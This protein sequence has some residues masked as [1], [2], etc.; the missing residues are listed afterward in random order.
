MSSAKKLRQLVK[1]LLE[2]ITR[3]GW[4]IN[5]KKSVLEPVNRITF[6]GAIWDQ[7]GVER[8]PEASSAI[9]SLLK[10]V[11]V[12]EFRIEKEPPDKSIRVFSDACEDGIGVVVRFENESITISGP[13]PT[14][15]I[16]V[17]TKN[18]SIHRQHSGHQSV[19]KGPSKLEGVHSKWVELGMLFWFGDA[20]QHLPAALQHQCPLR[21]IS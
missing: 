12:T 1:E 4:T 14:N 6:L 18:P 10:E 15:N 20:Y 9:W 21:A 5:T 19:E 17:W 7:N 2:L 11:S 13:S 16:L 3:A 8:T